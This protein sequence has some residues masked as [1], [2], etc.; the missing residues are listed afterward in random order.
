MIVTDFI[1]SFILFC[2]MCFVLAIVFAKSVDFIVNYKKTPVNKIGEFTLPDPYD[3]N[4]RITETS[5]NDKV[6]EAR[7]KNVC[8]YSNL[9]FIGCYTIKNHPFKVRKYIK[10]VLKVLNKKFL[11]AKEQYIVKVLNQ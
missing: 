2:L 7:N 4:W 1:F 9:L 10:T 8:I 5:F 11:K 6:I 3:S